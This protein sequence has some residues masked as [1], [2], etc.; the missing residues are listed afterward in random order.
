M[1]FSIN[2]AYKNIASV[3]ISMCK[4]IYFHIISCFLQL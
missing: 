2:I 3:Q 4:I 1:F